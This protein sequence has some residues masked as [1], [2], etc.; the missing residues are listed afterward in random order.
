MIFNLKKTIEENFLIIFF[1]S[2]IIS[3]GLSEICL[4]IVFFYV[5]F[6]YKAQLKYVLK[7]EKIILFFFIFIFLSS[8]LNFY[9]FSIKGVI[10]FRFF[11]YFIALTVIFNLGT[12]PKV[13]NFLIALWLFIIF[14]LLFQY[15]TGQDIFGFKSYR[16]TSTEID[17]DI[18]RLTGPFDDSRSGFYLVILTIFISLY[19]INYK[20]F[21]LLISINLINCFTIPLTGERTSLIYCLILFIISLIFLI[22]KNKKILVIGSIVLFIT[23]PIV[24]KNS[25]QIILD[26]NV[27]L[28]QQQIYNFT[29]TQWYAH[30]YTSIQIFNNHKLF[31][32][33]VRN[34]RNICSDNKYDG[35]FEKNFRCSTH[36]HNKYIEVLTEAGIVSFLFL[37]LII[38]SIFKLI[39]YKELEIKNKIFILFIIIILFDPLLPSKSFFNNWMSC[40]FW[41]I[42]ANLNSRKII[43][44][45]ENF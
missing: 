35:N 28:L 14:D 5:L 41:S 42:L 37:I 34:F 24:I 15:F 6:Q 45:K 36:P 31:G 11:L 23:T 43:Y 3:P 30:Y 12:K 13:I 20:K 29:E 19:L 7:N 21:I 44:Q 2:L 25:P 33:G 16:Y 18:L 40:I 22:E 26:R 9:D 27:N 1:I 38:Y 8:I 32:V 39:I 17:R 10:Y 4:I